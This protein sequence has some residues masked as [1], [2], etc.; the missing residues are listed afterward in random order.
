MKQDDSSELILLQE[1][2]VKEDIADKSYKAQS[3]TDKSFALN[4]KIRSREGQ[5]NFRI[6][7]FINHIDPVLQKIG[8]VTQYK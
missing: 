6:K 5:V 4:I 8:L 1:I 2:M 3:C 7:K